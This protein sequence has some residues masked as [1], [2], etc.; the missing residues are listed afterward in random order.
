MI[1]NSNVD[2]FNRIKIFMIYVKHSEFTIDSKAVNTTFLRDKKLTI[3][4]GMKGVLR[5]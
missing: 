4:A 2:Y 3:E 5:E 1:V